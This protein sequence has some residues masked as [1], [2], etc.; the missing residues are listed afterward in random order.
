MKRN[1][2][3]LYA[4]SLLQGMIFY[5]PIATLYRAAQGVTVSQITLIESISLILCIALEIPWGI[6]ADRIGYKKTMVF[7]CFLYV[8]SKIVFWQATC[9]AAFLAERIMLSIIFTGLSGVDTSILYLS[10]KEGESQKVFGIHNSLSTAGLLVAS[11]V[12]SLF[13][14]SDYKLS[15]GLTVISY[16]IAAL[17]SLF[18]IEV[19]PEAQR[20]P[21]KGEFGKILKETLSNRHF[22]LFLLS[23]A[24]LSE[25]HQT[26]TVFLNQVKYI[27]C[28]L[29]PNQIGYIYIAITLIGLLGFA[30]SKITKRLGIKNSGFIFYLLAILSTLLLSF[31]EKAGI[32]I[33]AIL[34]LRITNSLYQPFQMELQN[35]MI[36]TTNRATA[37]SVNAMV[38]DGV[39]A[40]T[41]LVFGVLA[42]ISL[43]YAFLF[44]A[45]LC[46]TA[47]AFF[48]LWFR[49]SVFLD[50]P[51]IKA[52]GFLL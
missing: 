48:F 28:G 19:R 18:L 49:H 30:S 38:I 34:L 50:T 3:L 37:L 40:G 11:I 52:E 21:Q 33:L 36:S 20:K 7:C 31:T 41:N 22:L 2:Y 27:N 6:V 51:H 8:I 16:G 29:K 39:G 13:I 26:I 47:L 46:L 42:D 23:V 9:F 25:S 44:G 14:G 35:R 24:F 4:I 5:S 15:G 17:L 32:S 10:A 1:I 45:A 12:Y 43:S